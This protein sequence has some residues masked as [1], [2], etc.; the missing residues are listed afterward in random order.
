MNRNSSD[1]DTHTEDDATNDNAFVQ[2][3]DLV[4]TASGGTC[5]CTH[6]VITTDEGTESNRQIV[7]YWDLGATQNIPDGDT[8]TL[9]DLQLTLG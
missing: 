7:A 1:F 3:K 6:A 5:T 4:F 8:L 2:I 9:Q